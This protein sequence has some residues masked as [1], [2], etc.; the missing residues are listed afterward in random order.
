MYNNNSNHAVGLPTTTHAR[1]T[2]IESKDCMCSQ[3]GA[4]S[5]AGA[6]FL[7]KRKVIKMIRMLNTSKIEVFHIDRYNSYV[8]GTEAEFH[9]IQIEVISPCHL[10]VEYIE[11]LN[12]F[13][14]LKIKDIDLSEE[15]KKLKEGK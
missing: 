15:L 12:V 8:D 1:F 11:D 10:L 13:K 9:V 5:T 4:P 7:I 2:A 6:P 14:E 3:C